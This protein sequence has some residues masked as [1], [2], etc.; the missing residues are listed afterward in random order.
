MQVL[1]Q[2]CHIISKVANPRKRLIL[3]LELFLAT[4]NGSIRERKVCKHIHGMI[5]NKAVF[6]HSL[7]LAVICNHPLADNRWR[8]YKDILHTVIQHV[9]GHCNGKAVILVVHIA[10][11][12]VCQRHNNGV[13]GEF[14]Q[15][16]LVKRCT[17]CVVNR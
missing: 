7:M 14:R 10:R 2:L 12:L 9:L 1:I 17:V 5:E 3:R 13:G 4:A 15:L 16:Q 11:Y 8:V 6:C